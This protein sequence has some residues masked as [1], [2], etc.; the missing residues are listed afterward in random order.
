MTEFI[1]NVMSSKIDF[2]NLSNLEDGDLCFT[3]YQ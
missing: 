3:L 2:A 1:F